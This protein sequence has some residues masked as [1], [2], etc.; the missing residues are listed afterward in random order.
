VQLVTAPGALRGV[1]LEL[2]GWRTEHGETMLRCWLIDGS[3]G[4]IPARWTDLP[5]ASSVPP[6][7]DVV[8][9]PEGWR[10]LGEQ[11]AALRSRRPRRGATS[12]QNGG[13]DVRTARARD[14][15]DT[16][17]GG[18][19]RGLAARAPVEVTIMLAR[20]LARLVEAERDE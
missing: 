1:E 15:R 16:G 7:L 14:G 12:G 17:R 4:T 18:G 6:A 19:V 9:S 8:A 20:L 5:H 11:L 3:V 13:R 2:F 10:R